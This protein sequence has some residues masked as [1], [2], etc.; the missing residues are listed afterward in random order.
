MLFFLKTIRITVQKN[1]SDQNLESQLELLT[2]EIKLYLQVATTLYFVF[3]GC[4]S[5][6]LSSKDIITTVPVVPGAMITKD[7]PRP[8]ASPCLRTPSKMC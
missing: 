6:Y 5:L 8:T 7:S 1:L 3:I 2:S 4:F